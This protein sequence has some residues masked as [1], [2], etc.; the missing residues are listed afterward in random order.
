[1]FDIDENNFFPHNFISPYLYFVVT[2]RQSSTYK[3]STTDSDVRNIDCIRT[4]VTSYDNE[5][6][7]NAPKATG[8]RLKQCGTAITQ[9]IFFKS[10]QQA[11]HI[12]PVRARNG[13]LLCFSSINFVLLLSVQCCVWICDKLDRVTTAPGCTTETSMV[14]DKQ[15]SVT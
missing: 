8:N 3:E 12:S 14:Y 2:T 13:C 10:L 1:M 4:L 11:T 5:T 6:H 7:N 9:S 15:Y